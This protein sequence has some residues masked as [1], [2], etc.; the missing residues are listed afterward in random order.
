LRFQNG[1]YGLRE[2]LES[3]F[4]EEGEG[5]YVPCTPDAFDADACEAAVNKPEM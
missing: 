4:E 5:P 1:P 2:P 3:Y